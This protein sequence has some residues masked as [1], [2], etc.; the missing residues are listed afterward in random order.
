VAA[1]VGQEEEAY[2][3]CMRVLRCE[4]ECVLCVKIF[5][6][7]HVYSVGKEDAVARH[8]GEAA[9]RVASLP[10]W[11]FIHTS[12]HTCIHRYTSQAY[13]L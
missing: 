12:A 6:S 10:P 8:A 13:L 11:L 3:R 2:L 4:C 5:L 9:A 7:M 1:T